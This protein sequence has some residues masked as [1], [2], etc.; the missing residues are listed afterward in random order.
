[1]TRPSVSHVSDPLA[2]GD[3]AQPSS[4]DRCDV[5]AGS[6]TVAVA[7]VVGNGAFVGFGV[8]LGMGDGVQVD[9]GV[10]SPGA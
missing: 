9:A 1:M 6:A 8:P 3:I 10:R 2:V 4:P 7:V 5:V